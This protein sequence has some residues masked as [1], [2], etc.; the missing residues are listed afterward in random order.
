MFSIQGIELHD[1]TDSAP[2][3]SAS[4]DFAEICWSR[5]KAE[6][7]YRW[8]MECYG[9]LLPGLGCSAVALAAES[10]VA[11][12]AGPFHQDL[13]NMLCIFAKC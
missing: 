4:G 3:D 8:I 11:A 9:L 13:K 1:E 2:G 7:N 12:V 10:C 5:D 6:N